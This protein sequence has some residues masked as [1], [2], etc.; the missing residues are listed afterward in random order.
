VTILTVNPGSSTLKAALYQDTVKGATTEGLERRDSCSLDTP[1]ESYGS[2]LATWLD[3]RAP[4][5]VGYR[6]VHGGSKYRA[7]IMLSDVVVSELAR[8]S[9]IDPDHM[10]QALTLI[11]ELRQRFPGVPHVA[12]F[13]TAFHR[14]MPR[15]AQLY[16]LPRALASAGVIRYGFHGLSYEYIMMR[17]TRDFAATSEG[18]IVIAHLGNGASMA[19][20]R[21]GVGIDTTMGFT[22]TGGL[23]MGTRCGDL[24]PGV[25]VYLTAEQHMGGEELAMLLN[26]QS[27]LLGM[28][29]LS[30]DMRELL[31]QE[32]TDYRARE[33]VDMFCYLARKHLGGLIAA[34]G[35]V[36]TLVFTGGIGERAPSV[37]AR[38]V[39]GLDFLGLEIDESRNRAQAD[40]ISKDTAGVTVRVIPTDEDFMVAMHTRRLL[41]RTPRT[42]ST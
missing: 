28:S 9:T 5:A 30:A 15:V 14:H 1:A 2:F 35:G 13:D 23:M 17:L 11:G 42:A 24:D 8:L 7:P 34:L 6:V 39:D 37:R 18:R 3:G 26:H 32:G 25:L 41:S 10:P 21:Q 33:A 27:G 16:P 4:E 31:E 36:D 38:I 19:A 29:D 22:P 40:V 20:V 12:C